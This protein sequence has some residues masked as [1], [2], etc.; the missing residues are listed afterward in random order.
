MDR[1]TVVAVALCVLFL[2]LY[3][4][5]LHLVGLDKYLGGPAS[6]ATKSAPADTGR[7]VLADTAAAIPGG[8]SLGSA[9][10]P[11]KGEDVPPADRVALAGSPLFG[12]DLGAG[13][14]RRDLTNVVYAT[15]DSVDAAGR[16]VA[17]TFEA[18]DSSGA[19]VRQTYRARP[20]SYAM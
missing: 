19:Y 8:S 2:L 17:L 10:H 1:K 5:L 11:R 14:D 15:R 7:L 16:R 4:P 3:R 13:D 20:D 18:R 12:L 9:A 6:T